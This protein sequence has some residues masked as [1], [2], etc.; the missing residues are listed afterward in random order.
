[1]CSAFT[2]NRLSGQQRTSITHVVALFQTRNVAAYG[3]AKAAQD[4]LTKSLSVGL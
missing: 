2:D 3:M 4:M 1:M